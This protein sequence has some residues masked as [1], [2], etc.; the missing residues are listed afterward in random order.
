M[1]KCSNNEK[2]VLGFSSHLML[3]KSNLAFLLDINEC[4][5]SACSQDCIN[6]EG[7]YICSCRNGYFLKYDRRTCEGILYIFLTYG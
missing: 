1:P 5:K 6:T 2:S 4:E 7:S 3:T